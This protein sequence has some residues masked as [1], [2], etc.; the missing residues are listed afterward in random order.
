MG[1]G[2]QTGASLTPASLCAR[3]TF[4]PPAVPSPHSSSHLPHCQ[5]IASGVLDVREYPTFDEESGQGVLATSVPDGEEEEFEIDL[6]DTEPTF[7]KVWG[8]L[9]FLSQALSPLFIRYG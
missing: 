2:R 6:N 1:E 9:G 8:A 5:L 7:L 4:T 3:T